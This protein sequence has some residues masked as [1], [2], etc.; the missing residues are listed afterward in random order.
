MP[1]ELSSDYIDIVTTQANANHCSVLNVE[2]S[3]GAFKFNFE[4]ENSHEFHASLGQIK[5]RGYWC[6]QCAQ[7]VQRSERF[8]AESAR[9]LMLSVGLEPLEPFEGARD[10]WKCK[11]LACGRETSKRLR[12]IRQTGTKVGCQSCSQKLK[13]LSQKTRESDAARIMLAAMAKPLEPYSRSNARWKSE[14]LVCSREIYP[15]LNNVKLGRNPCGYCAGKR[16]D[17]VEAI[18]LCREYGLEPLTPYPGTQAKWELKCLKCGSH[19]SAMYGNITRKKRYGWKSFGCSVC[20]YQQMGR[21]YSESPEV[22]RQKFLNADLEMIGEYKT[23]RLPIEARCLRCDAI[24][25]QTLN[26]VQNGKACKYC[27]HAGIKYGQPAYLYLIYHDEYKSIKV[28]ISNSEANL[29]RLSVHKKYGW[30]EYRVFNFD[31]ADEAEFYETMLL[32]WIRNERFLPHHLSRDLM[33]QG[34]FTETVDAEEISLPEIE[35]K[36]IALLQDWT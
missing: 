16:V 28:G 31:T 4:C 21:R 9:D 32:Q 24:T 23:A 5:K 17:E 18:S 35:V 11:C 14:C 19:V 33:P 27:F 34:G 3:S 10:P 8:T 1:R 12:S 6:P 7:R 13:S 2:H 25:K 15:T 36:L 26:G 22:A 20:T 30:L 29:N